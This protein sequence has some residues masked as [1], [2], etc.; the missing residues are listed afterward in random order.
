MCLNIMSDYD[1]HLQCLSKSEFYLDLVY[2]FRKIVGKNDFPHHFKNIIVRYKN[3]GHNIDVL[4][5]TTCLVVN[6]IKLNSFVYLNDCTT[7][8]RALD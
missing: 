3:I 4:R 1:L 7:V 6:P 5:Q 2:K 8:G